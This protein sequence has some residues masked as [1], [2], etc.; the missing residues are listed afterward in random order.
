MTSLAHDGSILGGRALTRIVR[1][2]ASIISATVMPLLF[3]ALFNLVMRRIM[4]ARGFDYAQLLPST[5]VVQAMLFT[6]MA[7][8]YNIADDKLSGIVGR[9]RSMPIHPLAPLVG[10]ASGDVIRAF[11]SL[12]LVLAVGIAAGMRFDAGL[13]WIPAYIGV[14]LLFVLAA[15]LVMGLIGF[16][17]SSPEAAVSIASI[18]YLPLLMLSTG[19]APME[20][21]PGW[22]QPFVEYQPVSVTIDALRAL[23]GDGDIGPTVTRALIWLV[24]LIAVFAVIG[25]RQYRK[26]TS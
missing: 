8:A 19:F 7:S 9:F 1:N 5:V 24:A 22:L 10:R 3:F 11:F 25:A 17:A 16:S 18:P 2:P 12:V 4:D 6:A 20:D 15:S 21:F 26:V 23:A 13:V 14:G